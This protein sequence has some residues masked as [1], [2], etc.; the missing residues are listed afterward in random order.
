MQ[1]QAEGEHYKHP[2]LNGMDV[3]PVRMRS[4]SMGGA[5]RLSPTVQN[6]DNNRG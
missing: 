2:Q 6:N 3:S 4:C 5:M 1:H